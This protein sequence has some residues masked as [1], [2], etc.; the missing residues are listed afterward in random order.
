MSGANG[1]NRKN[2]LEATASGRGNGSR[3]LGV[4]SLGLRWRRH[5]PR[6]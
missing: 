1:A 4:T 3:A 5:L 2:T 6:F